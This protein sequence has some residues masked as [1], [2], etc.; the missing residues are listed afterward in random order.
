MSWHI[1][2]K[3]YCD[4]P[5]AFTKSIASTDYAYCQ[6]LKIL[7]VTNDFL[8]MVGGVSHHVDCLFQHTSRRLEVTVLHICYEKVD[9]LED[10]KDGYQIFRVQASRRLAGKTN[11]TTKVIYI[12]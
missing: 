7:F 10:I 3:S 2:T 11:I 5:S 12:S 6:M 9:K 8:P 4:V 1:R